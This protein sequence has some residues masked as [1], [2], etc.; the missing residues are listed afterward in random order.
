M[1]ENRFYCVIRRMSETERERK[2]R[3]ILVLARELK[4]LNLKVKSVLDCLKQYLKLLQK[5]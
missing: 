4:I 3:K 1:L 5:Y 2:V